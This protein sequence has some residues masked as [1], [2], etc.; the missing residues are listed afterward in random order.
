MEARARSRAFSSRRQ[1]EFLW[2]SAKRVAKFDC[3]LGGEDTGAKADAGDSGTAKVTRAGADARGLGLG[4]ALFFAARGVP[5]KIVRRG[6]FTRVVANFRTREGTGVSSTASPETR[7]SVP[8][9]S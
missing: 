3:R 5:N 7:G 1:I 4:F 8:M 9:S 2:E 6:A